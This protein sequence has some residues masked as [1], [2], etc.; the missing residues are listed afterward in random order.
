MWLSWQAAVQSALLILA[1]VGVAAVLRVRARAPRW[2]GPLTLATEVSRVLVLYAVWQFTREQTVTHTAGA[3]ENARTLWHLERWLH[4]PNE[5]SWQQA[6][7]PHQWL[8]TFMDGYYAIAHIPVMGGVLVWLYW[9]HRD[10]YP[11]VRNILALTTFFSV[12]MHMHPLAPPRM[13]T[14]LGFVDSALLL[15]QSVYGANGTGVSNQLAAL[16]SL[17]YAWAIIGTVAV[18]RISTSRWRW[19]I[20]I[21][22]VLTTLAVT[23]T[24]N[25]WFMDGIVT[26]PIIAVAWAMQN[27]ASRAMARW[28]QARAPHDVAQDDEAPAMASASASE[29][30][31]S[32]AL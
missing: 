13:L 12:L 26:I 11:L 27:A 24:A 28:W 14:D 18:I 10:R 3:M 6:F 7:L 1:L 22:V 21:H 16:P 20:V 17:H 29:G 4:L 15:G 23:V 5:L 30:A 8:M 19:L 31:T 32:G 2:N 9:R 25:H